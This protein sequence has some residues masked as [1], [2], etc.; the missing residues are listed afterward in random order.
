MGDK[1]QGIGG[2]RNPVGDRNTGGRGQETGDTRYGH[3]TRDSGHV[4]R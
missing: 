4:W 3:E 2:R 1:K